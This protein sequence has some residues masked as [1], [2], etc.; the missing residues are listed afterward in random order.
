MKEVF[1]IAKEKGYTGD[2]SLVSLE[3]WLRLKKLI[4]CEIF[5][6]T[7]HKSWYINNYFLDLKKMKRIDHDLPSKKF[8]NYTDALE[9]AI[10]EM[11]KL[12]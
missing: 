10:T 7:F 4:H 8:E 5:Y 12:Q 11:L 1:I 3:W 6:S 2:N 9:Y